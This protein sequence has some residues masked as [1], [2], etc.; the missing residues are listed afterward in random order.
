MVSIW[1]SYIISFSRYHKL[2]C[3]RPLA[4]LA[5]WQHY[6]IS[7]LRLRGKDQ[8]PLTRFKFAQCD[9]LGCFL[10]DCFQHACRAIT[11]LLTPLDISFCDTRW[12]SPRDSVLLPSKA[13]QNTSAWMTQESKMKMQERK[14]VKIEESE[15]LRSVNQKQQSAQ[16]RWRRK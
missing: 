2:S 4:H 8:K 9:T 12:I 10:M 7:L 6:T 1:S 3:A 11:V 5:G 16:E 14:I 15:Y 13:K